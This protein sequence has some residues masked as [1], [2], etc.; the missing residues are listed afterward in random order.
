[1][2]HQST[3]ESA[4]LPTCLLDRPMPCSTIFTCL[5]T[6]P[7]VLATMFRAPFASFAPMAVSVDSC[8]PF[9]CTSKAA[10]F[11][12]GGSTTRC[13]LCQTPLTC[14]STQATSAM[15]S[16]HCFARAR[17]SARFCSLLRPIISGASEEDD[18]ESSP[19]DDD[20]DSVASEEEDAE[21]SLVALL[22]ENR[23]VPA[24]RIPAKRSG[25]GRAGGFRGPVAARVKRLFLR[26]SL[27]TVRVTRLV[28]WDSARSDK[29][30]RR[31]AA[32]VALG[33]ATE[34]WEP[35]RSESSLSF[36]P[37][38]NSVPGLRRLRSMQPHGL[39]F[40]RASMHMRLDTHSNMARGT[41]TKNGT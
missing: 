19:E 29:D 31:F 30:L 6:V 5:P 24:R 8:T 20:S 34:K 37:G 23:W 3:W 32:L 17:A 38:I 9:K 13:R 33:A 11:S 21:E 18:E 39:D 12:S 25:A 28:A 40:A 7:F 1:M 10:R 36:S 4:R 16:M 27:L 2:W 22:L 41:P 26:P 14:C 35:S 15:S